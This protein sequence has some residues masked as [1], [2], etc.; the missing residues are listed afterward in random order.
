MFLEG[1]RSWD[2]GRKCY[3][4][5][6]FSLFIFHFSLFSVLFVSCG[7]DRT[8]EYEEKTA[9]DHW[10]LS[11]MQEN[12]LWGDSI[13]K[14]RLDWKDYFTKPGTFFSKL[15]AFAPIADD[16]SWCEIDTLKE[17]HHVRGYF[18]HLDS[19][20]IDFV[21]MTDPT[22]STSRQF[23]RVVSVFPDSP[24]Q[25]CGLS[26]GDFIGVIDNARFTSSH[27]KEL[28]NGSSHSVVVSRLGMENGEYKWTSTDTL[29]M[30]ASRY[31]EDRAFP[32]YNL[33]NTSY[34]KVCYLMCNRLTEGP[35][36]R[37]PN[38]TAYREEML[39]YLLK[40]RSENPYALIL[41]L[42]LCNDGS[43]GM[44][45]TL[46]SYLVSDVGDASVFAKTFYRSSRSELNATYSYENEGLSQNLGLKE[47]VFI[48]SQYTRGAA[49][50]LIRGIQASMGK[51]YASVYGT[52]TDG[53]VVV[54]ESIQ[55]SHSVTLH[56]AVAYVAD[57]EGRYDYAVGIVPDVDFDELSY[58]FLY[59]Y[60]D[61][62]EVVL[63]IILQEFER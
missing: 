34:G 58:P 17:D 22:G 42:R 47:L 33:F 11:A 23:A 14:D 4:I 30:E 25:R 39:S 18:N 36:E 15:T 56:P 62:S 1:Q 24:A 45:R 60:G 35:S 48:T 52:T 40:M 59:P 54:T 2:K 16:Y 27:A 9:C 20:G 57:G 49:E 63:N 29:Q 53:Q 12:Y 21:V 61:E 19:Y 5:G 7:E 46:A 43:F 10:I 6:N 44:A 32:V 26:R 37:D 8:Y 50:W 38:S 31:V 13:K 41:D 55:S 3:W 51:Q 28:V